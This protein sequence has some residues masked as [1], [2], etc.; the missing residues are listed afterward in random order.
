ML[1]VCDKEYKVPMQLLMRQWAVVNE[2][3]HSLPPPIYTQMRNEINNNNIDQYYQ[4]LKN[5]PSL[6]DAIGP[7]GALFRPILQLLAG[8]HKHVLHYAPDG[9][10][11]A[12]P[13]AHDYANIKSSDI[14]NYIE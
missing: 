11:P 7:S 4:S 14:V 12:L 13:R 3:D 9:E 1:H 6:A 8:L 2:L 10:L 5:A